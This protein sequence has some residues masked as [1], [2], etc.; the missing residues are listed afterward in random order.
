MRRRPTRRVG[1]RR[2]QPAGDGR[3]GRAGGVGDGRGSEREAGT[4]DGE[5]PE[6][7][8]GEQEPAGEGD[9]S[10]SGDEVGRV[11]GGGGFDSATPAGPGGDALEG[12]E[13]DV[14][15]HVLGAVAAGRQRGARDGH[16]LAG[17]D[18]GA[19]GVAAG[20]GHL[21]LTGEAVAGAARESHLVHLAVGPHDPCRA[22]GAVGK[23]LGAFHL[24]AEQVT[25]D[26]GPDQAGLLAGRVGVLHDAGPVVDEA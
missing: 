5:G 15:G 26:P 4:G 9:A 8:G 24:D 16:G 10:L 23:V 19:D 3:A 12:A 1:Q 11:E 6:Q 18:R 2:P 21:D 22:G 13:L 17:T 25:G 20:G 14:A 7:R